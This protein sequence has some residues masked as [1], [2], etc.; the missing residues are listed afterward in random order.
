MIG[1]IVLLAV[2]EIPLAFINC[3]SSSSSSS[4]CA[5]FTLRALM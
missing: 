2:R 3:F 5:L 4:L 1:R